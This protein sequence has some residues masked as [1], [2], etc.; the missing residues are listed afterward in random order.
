MK[1]LNIGH[2]GA[3]NAKKFY[4]NSMEAFQQAITM[5]LEG[6]E[7]DI[8]ITNDQE[9]VLAHYKGDHFDLHFWDELTQKEIVLDPRENTLAHLKQFTLLDKKQKIVE[10]RELLE[11][12]RHHNMI[13][14]LEIKSYEEITIQKI[15]EMVKQFQMQTHNLIY[16]FEHDM[17]PIIRKIQ[18]ALGLSLNVGVL[19]HDTIPLKEL[20]F[21]QEHFQPGDHFIFDIRH[22]VENDLEMA[23]IRNHF[24]DFGHKILAYS[25]TAMDHLEG[26]ELFK[27]LLDFQVEGFIGNKPHVLQQYYDK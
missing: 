9:L 23:K 4:E 11:L 17:I 15:L 20:S 1:L 13:L 10:L 12:Y 2:R 19:Y 7:T 22:V 21:Y 14:C 25:T 16:T 5:G 3:Q 27:K 8:Y 6:I 24:K 26:E 18:K